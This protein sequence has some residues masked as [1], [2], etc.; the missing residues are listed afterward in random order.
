MELVKDDAQPRS[1]RALEALILARK[2]ER[3]KSILVIRDAFP[4]LGTP[5]RRTSRTRRCRL[6]Y[7]LDY[8][9][10]IRP[11]A[12]AATSPPTWCSGSSA[13]RARSTAT[14]RA[15]RAPAA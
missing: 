3:R 2:G 1:L 13:R 11:W 15:G 6:Y 14:P 12:R 9:D 10:T 8:Q 7:P 5:T 4:A